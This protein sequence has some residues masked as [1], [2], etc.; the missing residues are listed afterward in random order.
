MNDEFSAE[1]TKDEGARETTFLDLVAALYPHPRTLPADTVATEAFCSCGCGLVPPTGAPGDPPTPGHER[2]WDPAILAAR[3][4]DYRDRHQQF[5]L[6]TRRRIGW[7]GRLLPS[8]RAPLP[9]APAPWIRRI[10]PAWIQG[11][12][13]VRDQYRYAHH[14]RRNRQLQLLRRVYRDLVEIRAIT[15]QLVWVISS[16]GRSLLL[17][18]LSSHKG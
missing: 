12:G 11:E 6:R 16:S 10:F 4:Q 1:E 7:G 17:T 14:Q 8:Y 9:S 13:W 2:N 5:P 18:R 15:A 3:Q